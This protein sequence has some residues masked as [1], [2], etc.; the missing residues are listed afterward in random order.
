MSIDPFSSKRACNI[1]NFLNY[2]VILKIPV[3]LDIDTMTKYFLIF[4]QEKMR[5]RIKFLFQVIH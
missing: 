3:V 1:F 2:E 5:M 4:I